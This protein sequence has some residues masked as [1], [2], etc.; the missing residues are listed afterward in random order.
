M[1]SESDTPAALVAHSL[2]VA[3]VAHWA[4][5]YQGPVIGALL[6]APS[7]VD[8]PNYPVD[9]RGFAPM[10]LQ[11]LPFTSFIVAITMMSECR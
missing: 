6:V 10:P 7:D 2:S 4:A 9:A 3:L 11:R 5:R 8:A 1:I